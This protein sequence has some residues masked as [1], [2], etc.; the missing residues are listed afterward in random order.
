MAEILVSGYYGFHNAGDEA[1]LGGL[2][3]AIRQLEPSARFTVISGT[4][5]QTRRLHGVEAISRGD[6]RNIW[7]AMARTDLLISGGGSLL[8]DVTGVKSIPYYLGVV[9]M[10]KMRGAP[11]MFY[12]QGVG[13]V[14]GIIG[15]TLIP[16]IGN[17][18]NMIT[19]RDE[20]SARTLRALGVR[21]PKV[22]VT[23][24]AALAL[25]PADPEMGRPLLAG[26]GVPVDGRPVIG[27]AIRPW[28]QSG[29]M[30][31]A[32]A[33]GLDRFLKETGGHAVFI[34]MQW[35]KDVAASRN[36]AERMERRRDVTVLR[37]DFDFRQLHA[38]IACCDVMVGMRYHAL[39]LGA[40]NGVP[41]VGLS[42]DPKNDS[43]LRLLGQEAV[44][45]AQSLETAALVDVLRHS[46]EQAET[47]RGHYREV[48]GRLTPLS[49]RNAEI[50]LNLMRRWK[51]R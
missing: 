30:E 50:A 14:R 51:E 1:I 48:I 10:G 3:A 40:M 36:V 2:I 18:V 46:L 42:Y 7:R 34:P 15:R 19:V 27:V 4:A 20:D 12:A 17:F 47:I 23:A 6:F 22:E 25:G 28:M 49:R 24:D 9:S 26:A 32:L 29:R 39:V 33:A 31:A 43:F 13:P 8:Q 45:T 41:L 5:A 38:M 44:G 37:G 11:V 35:T 21:L 16:A